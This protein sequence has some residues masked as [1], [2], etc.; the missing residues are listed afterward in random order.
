MIHL[1]AF[2]IAVFG[3]TFVV[4]ASKISLPFRTWLGRQ[5]ETTAHNDVIASWALALLECPACLGFHLGWI[6]VAVGLAP[7]VF[8][9]GVLGAVF[10]AFYC[11]ASSLLLARLAGLD[12]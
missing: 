8:G 4:G 9:D 3:I 5:S 6:A 11:C 2:T 12:E 1:F 7:H 10:C